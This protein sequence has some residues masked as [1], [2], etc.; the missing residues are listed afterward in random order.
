MAFFRD[1]NNIRLLKLDALHRF[2]LLA[3]LLSVSAFAQNSNFQD[4]TFRDSFEESAIWISEVDG[5][6]SDGFNWEI[7]SPPLDGQSVIISVPTDV[8]VTIDGGPLVVSS[9]SS[10]ES[11]MLNTILTVNGPILN[12]GGMTI[13]GALIN[14]YVLPGSTQDVATG[15]RPIIRNVRMGKTISSGIGNNLAITVED[16]L[17][18]DGSFVVWGG[19]GSS[20]STASFNGNTPYTI[21]GAGDILIGSGNNGISGNADI[22]IG[23]D[24]T[25]HGYVGTF[26]PGST[27]INLGTV[28]SDFPGI[29]TFG[30]IGMTVINDGVMKGTDGG[31]LAITGNWTNNTSIA[32]QDGGT[33]HLGGTYNNQGTIVATD[34]TVSLAGEFTTAGLGSLSR[35]GGSVRIT[36]TLDNGN[37]PGLVLD[38]TTGSWE[39]G[40]GQVV[41]GA[42]DTLDG[43]LFSTTGRGI[44]SPALDGVTMNGTLVVAPSCSLAIVNNLTLNGLMRISGGPGSQASSINFNTLVPQTLSGTGT[45][46]ISANGGVNA[47]DLTVGPDVTLSGATGSFRASG[48]FDIMGTVLPDINISLKVESQNDTLV[49][50]GLFRAPSPSTITVLGLVSNDGTFQIESGS[51]IQTQR[52]GYT[53]SASGALIIDISGLGA[54]NH[55]QLN[56]TEGVSLAGSLT[57]KLINAYVPEIGDIFTIVTG[58]S[59]TGTFDMINGLDIGGGKQFDVVYNA[60]NVTFEVVSGP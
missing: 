28:H 5:N 26:A 1:W 40:G 56:S 21:N 57:V 20:F 39:I 4:A 30:K 14:A 27:L 42:L 18:L 60:T 25:L 46:R 2:I 10:E 54:A 3:L 51:M 22:T 16:G 7:G 49:N 43:T 24:I 32:I 59:I 38:A 12:N 31:S 41:G 47:G 50:N 52:A 36:G 8:V 9:I 37:G 34:S 58:T 33:L 45:M 13:A 15:F 48:S 35:T 29:L 23:P 55:G 17:T 11:L 44:N 6:W 19:S 53:Q